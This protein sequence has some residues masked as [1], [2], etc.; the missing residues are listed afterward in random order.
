MLFNIYSVADIWFMVIYLQLNGSSCGKEINKTHK[1]KA[2]PMKF[3][4]WTL[5]LATIGAVIALFVLSSNVFA[6]G[7]NET[8]LVKMEVQGDVILPSATDNNTE[9]AG[10][11]TA[12]SFDAAININSATV[13]DNATA[14][15]YNSDVMLNDTKNDTKAANNTCMTTF[16]GVQGDVV[17]YTA[18]AT[19][20]VTMTT[21]KTAA[22]NNEAISKAYACTATI[23][24][25]VQGDVICDLNPATATQNHTANQEPAH[26]E[27]GAPT[28]AQL[29]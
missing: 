7:Q 14:Q 18:M 1:G 28:G 19:D 20:S 15:N 29:A 9:N 2:T 17:Y 24:M 22:N 27:G 12:S 16:T 25:G 26:T 11:I 6:G 23:F 8:V 5:G 3:N 13:N 4:K 10:S 21:T